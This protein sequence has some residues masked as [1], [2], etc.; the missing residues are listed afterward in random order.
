[1]KPI[2][3]LF[4]TALILTLIGCGSPEPSTADPSS[5]DSHADDHGHE[6]HDHDE[7]AHPHSLSATVEHIKDE[8]GKITSAFASGKPQNAHHEL[9]AIGGVIQSLPGLATKA[10]LS[11]EQQ[12]SVAEITESL[13]DAFGKLDG[14]LHGGGDVEVDDIKTE[15]SAQLEKL[16][17][18]L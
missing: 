9:H 3:S 10:G 6:G 7:S 11:S 4:T 1:M 5:H 18:M 8:G 14:T 13:L 16:E 12:D 2:H 15:I 17:K